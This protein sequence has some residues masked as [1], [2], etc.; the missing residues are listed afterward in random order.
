M[1]TRQGDCFPRAPHVCVTEGCFCALTSSSGQNVGLLLSANLMVGVVFSAT[2]L[3]SDPKPQ[4]GVFKV[5]LPLPPV[6]ANFCLVS[7]TVLIQVFSLYLR[8]ADL[9]LGLVDDPAK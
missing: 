2:A 6:E 4:C 5:L 9:C 7:A 1:G 3:F 8:T